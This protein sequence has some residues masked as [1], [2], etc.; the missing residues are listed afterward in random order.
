MFTDYKWLS[1]AIVVL[2][3]T[4]LM[5]V[6]VMVCNH[7]NSTRISHPKEYDEVQVV[8]EKEREKSYMNRVV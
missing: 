2:F 7:C 6:S 1:I 3:G 5:L 4:I 8:K